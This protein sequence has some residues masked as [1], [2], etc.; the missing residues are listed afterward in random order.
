LIKEYQ[1]GWM[2]VM[3]PDWMSSSDLL[4]PL[5]KVD[6][7]FTDMSAKSIPTPLYGENGRFFR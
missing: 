6:L 5:A 2:Y 7:T 3:P 1:A 4:T